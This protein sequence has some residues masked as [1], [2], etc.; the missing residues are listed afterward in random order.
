MNRSQRPRLL[1]TM[2]ARG[3]H[4]KEAEHTPFIF[5]ERLVVP[6]VG[7]RWGTLTVANPKGL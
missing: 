3:L 4:G 6:L 1:W 2:V 7:F 5:G